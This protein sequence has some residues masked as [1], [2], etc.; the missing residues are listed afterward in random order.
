MRNGAIAY[1]TPDDKGLMPAMAHYYGLPM[2]GYGG[3]S[4]SKCLDGQA[5]LE[6][7]TSL[8]LA[9]LT[10]AHL[11]HD[12]GYLEAGLSGA[13]EQLV[14]C[15]EVIE[16]LSHAFA[17]VP[18]TE[19][20]LALEVIDRLGPDGNYL[21]DDHTLDHFRE[22][23]VPGLLDQSTHDIWLEAGGKCLFE[24]AR[25]RVEAVLGS[26]RP[27]PLPEAAKAAVHAI[28]EREIARIS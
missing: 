17:P 18:I 9:T 26:H 23:W 15:D 1:F 27:Y 6:A 25:D 20:T 14:I 12:M 13:L 16:W 11:V 24:S 28:L 22:R 21:D 4:D 2:F 10:G 19:E 8:T 3:F 5:S 7:A